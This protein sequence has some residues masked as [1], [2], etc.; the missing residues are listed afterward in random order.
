MR[1]VDVV[2]GFVH[3]NWPAW[4]PWPELVGDLTPLGL[5]AVGVLLG[6][7]RAGGKARDEGG[8]DA[9]AWRPA[10]ASR[11]RAKCTRHLWARWRRGS[12]SR[13]PSDPCGRRRST[14]S[15]HA[16]AP[17]QRAQELGPEGLGLRRADRHAQPRRPWSLTATSWGGH[18]DRD[19]APGLAHLHIACCVEPQIGPVALQRSTSRKPLTLSSISPHSL[20]TWLLETAFRHAH[21]LHQYR[22]PAGRHPWSRPPGSP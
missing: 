16:A 7:G 14:A 18:R 6:E 5:R 20:E 3:E 15:R 1:R 12:G 4:A 9:P 17:G 2:L 8:D 22:R 21:G 10:W 11:L 19:D 13:R